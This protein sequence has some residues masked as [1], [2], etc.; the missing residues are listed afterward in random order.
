MMVVKEA[1]WSR[2]KSCPLGNTEVI[3]VQ[4]EMHSGP[5]TPRQDPVDRGRSVRMVHL[6]C[7]CERHIHLWRCLCAVVQI[8]PDQ[9]EDVEATLMP[10]VLGGVGLS[11]Q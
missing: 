11:Q 9:P 4:L 3:K 10:M 1:L 8:S 7:C 5:D 2:R 6:A